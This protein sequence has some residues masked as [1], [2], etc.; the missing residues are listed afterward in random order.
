MNVFALC[1]WAPH[2]SFLY[3][4]RSSKV[5]PKKK[6]YVGFV[7]VYYFFTILLIIL[8]SF[9][10]LFTFQLIGELIH[11]MGGFQSVRTLQRREVDTGSQN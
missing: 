3:V 6:V 2:N 4:D 8:Y 9:N 7:D 1:S 11:L 5:P 10:K